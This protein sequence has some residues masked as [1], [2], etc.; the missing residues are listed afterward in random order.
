MRTAKQFLTYVAAA[1]FQH[2]DRGRPRPARRRTSTSFADD[3]RGQ[4][5]PALRGP[6]RRRAST[7]FRAAGHVLRHRRHP[8]GRRRRRAG[9]LPLAARAVRGGGGAERRSSTTTPDAGRP[10]VRFA[11]CKRPEVLDEAVARLKG[12][13]PMT[14]S[15][16]D[17]ARHRAWED[18]AATFAHLAPLVAAA[19]GAGAR[20]VVLTEMF[21]TGFS[22]AT[23]ADRRA[24]GRPEHAS[25]S[26][27]RPR[28]HG[29]WVGGSVPSD[30]DGGARPVNRF[31]LAGPDGEL[32][33]YDKIHPFT[34]LRRARALRRRRRAGH[35]RVEGV[36]VTLVRLLR[37]AL[38]RRVLG[39][40]A[41]TP[42]A[43]W[44]WPTGPPPAG[45]T[46]R[47]CSWPGRSRTRPTSSAST[48]SAR[49]AGSPTPATA[50][51]STRWARCWP[52]AAGGETIL[53]GDVDPAVVAADQ[54]AVPVPGRPAPLPRTGRPG[55]ESPED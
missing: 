15:P 36:R 38:R 17:P 5:R 30:P 9:V 10:L 39:A 42:T 55:P 32:H 19:A 40:G 7:S 21:P 26:S 37:P 53:L 23:G 6:A 1:P 31:V 41:P 49:A 13:R 46:G 16:A 44:W 12:L 54:G 20:L 50:A 11:F 8:L 4:A 3:L 29:V 2:A 48:G 18:R 24:G 51:S 27:S 28:D 14:R 47:R 34:L 35:G 33:R 25:S 45:P 22:M 52:A 43:T